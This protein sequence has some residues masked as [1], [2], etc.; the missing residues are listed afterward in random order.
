MSNIFDKIIMPI[1]IIGGAILVAA[2]APAMAKSNPKQ[3][4]GL[5]GT[6]DEEASEIDIP[7]EEEVDSETK[8]LAKKIFEKMKTTSKK[9]KSFKKRRKEPELLIAKAFFQKD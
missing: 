2:N 1:T 9:T 4:Q 6:P 7:R 3:L 8:E 5:S